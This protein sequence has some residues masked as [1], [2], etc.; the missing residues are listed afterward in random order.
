MPF[1]GGGLPDEFEI[2]S[3]NI[4]VEFQTSAEVQLRGFSFVY[5]SPAERDP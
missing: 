5:E 4:F 1:A 3:E 2:V